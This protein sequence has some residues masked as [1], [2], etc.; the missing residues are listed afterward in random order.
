[1]LLLYYYGNC[2]GHYYCNY[3]SYSRYHSLATYVPRALALLFHLV[4]GSIDQNSF[5]ILDNDSVQ[6]GCI[7][8]SMSWH[9]S[10]SIPSLA[11]G[12]NREANPA[13]TGP[14]FPPHCNY[15]TQLGAQEISPG[16]P[17]VSTAP[18]AKVAF[19]F[20]VHLIHQPGEA[21]LTGSG[22]SG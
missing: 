4:N 2:K 8:I 15:I 17:Q 16:S 22:D 1:M 18:S 10:L 13:E 11:T 5:Q 3:Y 20:I 19:L 7:H 9:H 21:A 14:T 6:V 12:R